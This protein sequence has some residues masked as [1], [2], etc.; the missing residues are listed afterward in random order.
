M[1]ENKE[2]TTNRKKIDT[3]SSLKVKNLISDLNLENSVR[4]VQSP[5]SSKS[6][7]KMLQSKID[8]WAK[9]D[10]EYGNRTKLF[11]D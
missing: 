11:E 10:I 6:K 5:K 2:E 1:D 8:A 9:R 4:I 7:P 3:M